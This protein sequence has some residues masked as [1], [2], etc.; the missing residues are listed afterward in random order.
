MSGRRKAA[1]AEPGP[2]AKVVAA[3]PV[4]RRQKDLLAVAKGHTV[5]LRQLRWHSRLFEGRD[6]PTEFCNV[7]VVDLD[8]RGG[9][10]V[11]GVVDISWT[12]VRDLLKAT[13]PDAW[14][15][16][17]LIEVD[18]GNFAAVELEPVEDLDMDE[19]AAVLDRLEAAAL[20]ARPEQLQLPVADDAPDDET[21][22]EV[23]E[24]GIPF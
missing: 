8:A 6:E 23:K 16:G 11:L 7:G 20:T 15:A 13:D 10:R 4:L 12:R 2:R 17:K 19:V 21:G 3:V 1:S 22:E 9:P 14:V 18:E 24:D 5:A